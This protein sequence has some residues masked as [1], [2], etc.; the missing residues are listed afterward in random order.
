MRLVV[1][2]HFLFRFDNS[3]KTALLVLFIF[4]IFLAAPAENL[5]GQDIVPAKFNMSK[6]NR[7]TWPDSA[8]LRSDAK[9]SNGRFDS[10]AKPLL[11][12]AEGFTRR[13]LSVPSLAFD[14]VATFPMEVAGSMLSG[15]AIYARWRFEEPYGKGVLILI[16]TP[17][18]FWYSVRLSPCRVASQTDVKDLLSAIFTHPSALSNLRDKIVELDSERAGR[19]FF[20]GSYLRA[21][22]PGRDYFDIRGLATAGDCFLSANLGKNRADAEYREVKFIPERFPPLSELAPAWPTDRLWKEIGKV[23]G[24]GEPVSEER[25]EFLIAELLKRGITREDFLRLLS[26]VER[27]NVGNRASRV[28][29]VILRT[30][31]KDLV[32]QHFP[33]VMALYERLQ[34]PINRPTEGFFRM[35]GRD[36]KPIYHQQAIELLGRGRIMSGPLLYFSRCG[37][38]EEALRVV[39]RSALP[40]ELEDQ[41]RYVLRKHDRLRKP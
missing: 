34:G 30:G 36:C 6:T 1:P 13:F 11:D 35:A 8:H 9:I 41:R 18:A 26:D 15:D 39:E 27:W 2:Y 7:D 37:A 17:F 28:M 22:T 12:A 20:Y 10:R 29:S 40:P 21:A 14:K 5:V 25:D 3:V 23:V 33:A 16:D 31:R 38:S 32:E 4:L 24:P 19:R